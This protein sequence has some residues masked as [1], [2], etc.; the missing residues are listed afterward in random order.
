MAGFVKQGALAL[1]LLAV[2]GAQAADPTRP[3]DN[4]TVPGEVPTAGAE[5]GPRLQ[6]V[7]IPQRG[8]PVAVISGVTVPLGGRFGEATLSRVS[9]HEVVLQGA[10]GMTR[11]Y[12]TPDVRKQVVPPTTGRPGKHVKDVP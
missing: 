6:S 10:D 7:L 8:K 9:E 1:G 11:L 3:P 12:L 4:W 2:L 5:Q